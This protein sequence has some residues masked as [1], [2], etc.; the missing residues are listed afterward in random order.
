M[1]D[2]AR[3]LAAPLLGHQQLEQQ[4]IADL[5]PQDEEAKMA[6]HGEREWAVATALYK[7]CHATN[8]ALTVGSLASTVNEL[9]GQI[10]ETY[11]LEPRAVGSVLQSLGLQTCKLGNFGRGLRMTQNL[12]MQIHKLV[13]DLGIKR[14]DI[15]YCQAVDAGYAGPFCSLCCHRFSTKSLLLVLAAVTTKCGLPGPSEAAAICG[16]T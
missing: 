11:L 15:M 2:L 3:A 1:K 14:T 7:E 10:G 6:R 12:K 13:N 16:A 9:L 5:Q 8:G 4:L